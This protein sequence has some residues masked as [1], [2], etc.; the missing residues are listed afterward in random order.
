MT[1]CEALANV[2]ALGERSVHVWRI[3]SR[4][5]LHSLLSG[6]FAGVRQFELSIGPAGKPALPSEYD[7]LQFNMSHS[8]DVTLVAVTRSGRVGLDV[9]RIKP[10]LAAEELRAIAS[11]FFSADEQRALSV[12]AAAER[13][14][15]FY[16]IWC[17]K[18]AVL[19]GTG[20]GLAH[21][22]DYFSVVSATG[23]PCSSLT[24]ARDAATWYLCEVDAGAGYAGALACDFEPRVIRMC[25]LAER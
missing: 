11:R 16:Q 15:R 13:H 24:T 2:P 22:T 1:R 23:A 19:K 9:E 8:S 25:T 3:P 7:G 6:Y 21:G 17:R 20:E 18:E 12:C 5:E 10:E 14:A 4:G